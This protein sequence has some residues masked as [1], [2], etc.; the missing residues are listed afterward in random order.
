MG[1]RG[2]SKQADPRSWAHGQQR[3]QA[4]GARGWPDPMRA[5][6]RSV[7]RP[8]RLRTVSN[9]N[10]NANVNANTNANASAAICRTHRQQHVGVGVGVGVGPSVTTDICHGP[11]LIV[12]RPPPSHRTALVTSDVQES[13][14]NELGWGCRLSIWPLL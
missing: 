9:A 6:V 8:L 12:H 4:I 1:S 14:G 3:P 7:Q 10:A 2:L 11:P 5:S 13:R